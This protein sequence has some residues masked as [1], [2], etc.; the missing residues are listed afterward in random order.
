[1]G[2]EIMWEALNLKLYVS[3]SLYAL[4]LFTP[5]KFQEI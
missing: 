3:V 5:M 2:S 1:M 4:M